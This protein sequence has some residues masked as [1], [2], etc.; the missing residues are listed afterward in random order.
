MNERLLGGAKQKV[1]YGSQAPSESAEQTI[2]VKDA[3]NKQDLDKI[4]LF[5][6]KLQEESIFAGVFNFFTLEEMLQLSYLYWDNLHA[7]KES[8]IGVAVQHWI[9][10]WFSVSQTHQQVF[11][12]SDRM[13]YVGLKNV[14][15]WRASWKDRNKDQQKLFKTFIACLERR[16]KLPL[17][18]Y[19]TTMNDVCNSRRI[20]SDELLNK[21]IVCQNRGSSE[22]VLGLSVTRASIFNH[23]TERKVLK[24]IKNFNSLMDH[25]KRFY[26]FFQVCC[27]IL[28]L[29]VGLM[30][31]GLTEPSPDEITTELPIEFALMMVAFSISVTLPCMMKEFS[32]NRKQ[33][34]ENRKQKTE[35]H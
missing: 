9:R 30:F 5:W 35:L 19:L 34:T 22:R 32:L 28:I 16:L 3:K 6:K 15:S 14:E 12:D 11:F 20:K 25:S 1:C 31:I 7:K 26:G 8:S 21:F 33:K 27:I 10:Q 24:K 18:A 13:E 23:K 29:L 17:Y 2:H 4:G